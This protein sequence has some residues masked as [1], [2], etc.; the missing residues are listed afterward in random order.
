MSTD[1]VMEDWQRHI[2]DERLELEVKLYHLNA[3]LKTPKYLQLDANEQA[4]LIQ[5]K[6][7]MSDYVRILTDRI[8]DFS[9]T[10]F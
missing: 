9:Y 2:I 4:R 3:F 6:N 10:K 5:Q 1:V 8:V 7:I